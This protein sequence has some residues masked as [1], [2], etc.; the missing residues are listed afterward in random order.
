MEK[1][2]KSIQ[3]AMNDLV[4]VAVGVL[5]V[6]VPFGFWRTGVRRFSVVLR[7]MSGSDPG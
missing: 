7:G 4:A 6:N 2:D 1:T 5:I 3:V